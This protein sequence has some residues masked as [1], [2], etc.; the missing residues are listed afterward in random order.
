MQ[1]YSIYIR[2]GWRARPSDILGY[3]SPVAPYWRKN[4]MDASGN[5]RSHLHC[6]NLDQ[7]FG[8]LSWLNQS[9]TGI[10]G[11]AKVERLVC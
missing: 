5:E 1:G 11:C 10:S 3:R 6:R 4:K 8:S 2:F 7:F 9:N